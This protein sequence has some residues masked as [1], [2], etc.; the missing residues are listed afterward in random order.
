MRRNW[1]K[2][3]IRILGILLVVLFALVAGAELLIGLGVRSFSQTAQAHF[4]GTRVEAL[5]AMV[6]CQS[7]RLQDRNHAVWALGQ[8][9]D[10]RSLPVLE[11]HYTGAKCDHRKYLCQGTLQVALRHLRHQG[12]NRGESFLW[13]WMLAD[14]NLITINARRS[15]NQYHTWIASIP[16]LALMDTDGC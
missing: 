15:P 1:G 4:H 13:R 14:E 2:Y 5:M 11:K 6:E 12:N 16:K 8:L 9:D 3:T 7:C 10:P